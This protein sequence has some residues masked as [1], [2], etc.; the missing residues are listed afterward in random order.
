MGFYAVATAPTQAKLGAGYENPNGQ[1]VVR[2]TGLSGTDFG[3][4][5]YELRR[6]HCGHHYGSNGS[7][8]HLRKCPKRP[9][10]RPGIPFS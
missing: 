4:R 8:I 5:A 10:G 2:S 7:G 1:I 6:K 9:D 3:Q